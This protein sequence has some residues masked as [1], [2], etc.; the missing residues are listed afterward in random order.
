MLASAFWIGGAAAWAPIAGYLLAPHV[1]PARRVAMSDSSD[2]DSPRIL[3]DVFPA[4]PAMSDSDGDS[5][6]MLRGAFPARPA[7]SDSDGDS[8]LTLRG[9]G[10][11]QRRVTMMADEPPA[12]AP[13]P[14]GA[15]LVRPNDASAL[16]TERERMRM[17]P[18]RASPVAARPSPPPTPPRPPTT[19][20]RVPSGAPAEAEAS[21]SEDPCAGGPRGQA[22]AAGA[23][24][25]AVRLGD[26]ARSG[27]PDLYSTVCR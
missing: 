17:A 10:E 21:L 22:D 27:L 11:F 18:V 8:P 13:P 16:M 19:P 20:P 6:L 12:D 23:G 3:R 2:G 1:L 15:L 9:V 7:M 25:A 4:R 14:E 26:G 5:P 24:R